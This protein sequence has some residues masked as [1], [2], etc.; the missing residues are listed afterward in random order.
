MDHSFITYWTLA[1]ERVQ[2]ML[3]PQTDDTVL[4]ALISLSFNT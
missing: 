2:N 4:V 1:R 3:E